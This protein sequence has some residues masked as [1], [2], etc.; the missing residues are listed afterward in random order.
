M[1]DLQVTIF[2]TALT[3]MVDRI[4]SI[5]LHTDTPGA[6]GANELSGGG[7]SRQTPDWSTPDGGVVEINDP[8]AY[9]IPAGNVIEHVGFWEGSTWLGSAPLSAPEPFNNDGELTI[10]A[11]S[12]TMSNA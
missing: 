3:A 9:N 4:D 5:S 2:N 6:S 7:Y 1:T 8:L 10:Q 11:L 12:I